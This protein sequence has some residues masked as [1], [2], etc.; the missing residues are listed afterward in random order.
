MPA[1][2]KKRD[3]IKEMT[4]Q[5]LAAMINKEKGEGV[6]RFAS[7]PSLRIVRIPTGILSVDY[8]L[9][10]GFARNR[11]TEL[12]GSSAVGKT[13]VTL[14]AI[15]T[16]QANDLRCGFMDVERT[17]DPAWAERIGIDL[18]ELAYSEQNKHA[19]QCVDVLETWLVSGLYDVI[20]MDSIAALLPEPEAGTDMSAGSMG[21]EQAKLMSK[22][23]R[24]L[25]A[26]NR[27]TALVFI[28]QTRENIGV[29]FGK[30][31]TTSGGRA[32]THYAGQRLE[33][34]RTETLKRKG[35][36]INEKTGEISEGD[37]VSG[38]RV[39]VRTEKDKTGG[40]APQ[41]TSTF[42]FDYDEAC[43]DMIEDLIYV[44]RRFGLVHK[45]G[46]KWWVDDYEDE[47]VHGR[48]RFKK[49]LNKNVAVAEELEE[50]IYTR[51]QEG[52]GED[53]EVEEDDE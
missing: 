49:W 31:T 10:G 18:E 34:V 50:L 33:L 43:H 19:N 9:G 23:L 38:H 48:S 3:A 13:Y 1:T 41:Q 15:A 47:K 42:V 17:F 20:V 14:H 28:N 22:A 45:S 35:K 26:A 11:Y 40:S 25:T 8:R 4:P 44:G 51:I 12:F 7:D 16:A 2:K 5:Q 53:E 52:D 37:V 46:E 30:K 27:K 24:K 29:M 32:M 36:V 21:M 6:M 39:L